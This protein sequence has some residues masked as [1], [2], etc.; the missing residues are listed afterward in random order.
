MDEKSIGLD[1]N[2]N[3][4][5]RLRLLVSLS[6]YNSLSKEQQKFL[7]G[8]LLLE[9]RAERAMS[10]E[11]KESLAKKW[12][13]YI[14]RSVFI[15]DQSE[16][17][18][19]YI[20]STNKAKSIN[21]HKAVEVLEFGHVIEEDVEALSFLCSDTRQNAGYKYLLHR[22]ENCELP[23]TIHFKRKEDVDGELPEF[24]THSCVYLGKSSDGKY[25]VWEKIG[26]MFPYRLVELEDVCKTYEDIPFVGLR[27]TNILKKY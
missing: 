26:Y 23:M 17:P 18:Y 2:H 7:R 20:E 24:P 9:S 8:S 27:P 15:T 5:E 21:C 10:D 22:L 1:I 11:Y 6:G 3:V 12:A 25:W 14:A 19:E 13:K 4:R 16:K